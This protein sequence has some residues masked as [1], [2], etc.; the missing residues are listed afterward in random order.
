MKALILSKP[1]TIEIQQIEK[2]ACRPGEALIRIKAA[3]LNHRDQWCREGKYP[4][5][6]YGTILGSDGAG[7]VEAI[8][9]DSDSGWL[10]QEVLINP[11]LSWGPDPEV[12]APEYSILGMPKNGTFSEYV[13]VDVD[14]LHKKPS[15]LNF[16]NAAA[17]PLGGLTAYR[18]AFRHGKINSGSKVLVTGIGGGVAQ[19]ALLFAKAADAQ[20]YV[21]S[22]SSE[23]IERAIKK[24]AEGGFNYEEKAWVKDALKKSGGFDVIIDSAGGQQFNELI[25]LSKPGGKIVFY[26]ATTGLPETLNLHR[27]FWAQITIQGSTMGNDQEFAEMLKF[28]SEHSIEPIIDSIR[29]FDKI[30]SAFDDMQQ[31]KQ[32]GKLV[33]EF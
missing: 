25:K 17:F 19:F 33:V 31:G 18:A 11:N 21:T 6:E 24:G 10:E 8:G 22:S 2:P 26:G 13:V 32:A 7:I 20:V 29:P 28:I 3:A 5:I 23:K 12:Q 27:V 16:I 9:T 15:Y 4:N 30:I 1:Q 14:R